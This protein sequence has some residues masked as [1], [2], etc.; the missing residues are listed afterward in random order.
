[1]PLCEFNNPINLGTEE[2][3]DWE[4]SEML[5]DVPNIYEL[6]ENETTEASFFLEKTFTYGDFFVM[7]FL[8][9]FVLFGII[10]L[11]W[12]SFTK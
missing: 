7:F 9:V 11:T 10:K 1:M 6:V 8:T 12:D 5:C 3:P 4:Y 2:L